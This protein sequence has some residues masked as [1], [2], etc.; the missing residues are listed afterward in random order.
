MFQATRNCKD[1]H[2]KCNFRLAVYLC[3]ACVALVAVAGFLV[4]SRHVSQ[5]NFELYQARA[6]I[7]T[8]LINSEINERRIM[9]MMA[10]LDKKP[11]APGIGGN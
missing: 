7:H 10:R 3:L 2:I 5:T 8:C 6:T 9:E 4:V 11:R 1:L